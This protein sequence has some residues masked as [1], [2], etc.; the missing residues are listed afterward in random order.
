M[1]CGR[2]GS[3]RSVVAVAG[4][5]IDLSVYVP[6]TYFFPEPY[7]SSLMMPLLQMGTALA[8]PVDSFGP[9]AQAA[10]VS[11]LTNASGLQPSQVR[12]HSA[13]VY[14]SVCA[15]CGIVYPRA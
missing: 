9:S 14:M 4:L 12:P 8:I 7:A 6:V 3:I 15:L 5:P 2:N 1:E 10:F 11:K 13:G